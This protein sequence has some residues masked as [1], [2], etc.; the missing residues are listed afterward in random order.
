LPECKAFL[1]GLASMQYTYIVIQN[2]FFP[3][4]A[5]EAYHGA[6]GHAAYGNFQNKETL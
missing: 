2:K 4:S 5:P 3:R 1:S 6:G